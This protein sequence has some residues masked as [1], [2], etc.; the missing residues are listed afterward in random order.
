LL[1]DLILQ[2]IENITVTIRDGKE[3]Y[4]YKGIYC[5]SG[6]E[7]LFIQVSNVLKTL[8]SLDPLELSEELALEPENVKNRKTTTPQE[9]LALQKEKDADYR[10]RS[11]NLKDKLNK[12]YK[13]IEIITHTTNENIEDSIIMQILSNFNA[14]RNSK[15]KRPFDLIFSPNFKYIGIQM[16]PNNKGKFNGQI[17][18]A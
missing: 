9:K 16:I 10:Q 6:K 4:T 5:I 8:D 7:E 11:K 13:K 1:A 12:K 18:L 14:D 3:I 15:V 2:E 17:I